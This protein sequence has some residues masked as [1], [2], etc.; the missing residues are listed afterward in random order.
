M[1]DGEPIAADPNEAQ[2]IARQAEVELAILLTV[3][4]S[5]R[6]ALQ[7]MTRDRGNSRGLSTLRFVARSFERHLIRTRVLA[8]YGGYMHWITEAKPYLAS[9]V[10]ALRDERAELQANFERIILRLEYVSPDDAAAIGKVCAEF[11]R[12]LEQL[13]SH[14]QKEGDLLQHSFVQEEGGEA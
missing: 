3:E 8:D 2:E 6:L 5:L 1:K 12:H 11:E 13:E 14:G 10:I 7:W 9:E 4:Q